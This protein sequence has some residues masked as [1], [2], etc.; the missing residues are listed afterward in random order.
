MR[1]EDDLMQNQKKTTELM[2]TIDENEKEDKGGKSDYQILGQF[3]RGGVFVSQDGNRSG[4]L[5]N[6]WRMLSC[7]DPFKQKQKIYVL[8]Y[9]AASPI[10]NALLCIKIYCKI[11]LNRSLNYHY[12][13]FY[14][15]Y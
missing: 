14:V 4:K 8:Q 11:K 10:T 7:R 1:F 13:H 5:P 3:L 9:C 15:W 2:R 6:L 12:A